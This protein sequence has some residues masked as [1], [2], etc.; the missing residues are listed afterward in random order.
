MIPLYWKH[1]LIRTPLERPAKQLQHILKM[2]R[3]LRH[4]G[5]H[6]IYTEEYE[7]EKL[8]D[9]VLRP[10]SNCVDVGA[11]IGSTLSSIIRRAP[12]G[13]HIAVEPV[14]RKAEW[15]RLKFPEVDIRAIALADTPGTKRFLE[16]KECSGLSR[17]LPSGA[18]CEGETTVVCDCLDNIIDPHRR[19]DFVKIDVEGAELLALRGG[20]SLLHRDHPIILFESSPEGGRKFGYSCD[21]LFRLLNERFGYSIYLIRDFLKGRNPIAV[22]TFI[23][24]HNYPFRAMNYVAA[25]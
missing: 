14:S 24:S 3:V 12:N 4:P 8:F 21:Q 10:N 11:H 20:S 15:L 19:V 2:W 5:L 13:K 1:A 7:I 18:P 9:M 22:D 17:L 23:H 25:V 6:N 16:C